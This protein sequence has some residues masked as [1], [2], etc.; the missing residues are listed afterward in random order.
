LIGRYFSLSIC[1]YIKLSF[2]LYYKIICL[3]YS[4]K[5]EREKN[6]I[7]KMPF[8]TF[9]QNIICSN[10][11]SFLFHKRYLF[12]GHISI[13]EALNQP[14]IIDTYHHGHEKKDPISRTKVIPH[15]CSNPV[16]FFLSLVPHPSWVRLIEPSCTSLTR[17][18][19]N[20]D[21]YFCAAIRI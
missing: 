3:W 9:S 2:A 10:W 12:W 1:I 6:D 17:W 11:I 16:D 13:H 4:W 21:C 8:R 7:C 15:F 18:K 5:T 20:K 19:I 14:R